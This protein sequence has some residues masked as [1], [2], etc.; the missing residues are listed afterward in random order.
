MGGR[1]PGSAAPLELLHAE[2]PQSSAGRKIWA[3]ARTKGRPDSAR[4][5][6]FS[7]LILDYR[8]EEWAAGSRDRRH[9]SSCCTRRAHRAAQAGKSGHWP[10]RRDD[11]TQHATRIFQSSYWTIGL[12]NGR[13]AAGI[14]GTTRAAARG[15]PTEQRRQENLGTGPYEGTTRLSTR[16]EFFRA[17][18]G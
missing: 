3:L 18:I 12:K 15:E 5:E 16:R 14:G 7:E 13:Q 4:D 11:P 17:H 9:H 8:L 10:V 6:N 2:S 1:Q